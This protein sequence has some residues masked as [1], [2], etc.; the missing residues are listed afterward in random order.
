MTSSRQSNAEQNHVHIF[1]NHIL[2][3]G[4][5]TTAENPASILHIP[6][7]IF[8]VFRPGRVNVAII[9]HEDSITH[10]FK[11]HLPRD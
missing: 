5:I 10:I 7:M 2:I 1:E 8:H 3:T 4:S 11:T 9:A 6:C